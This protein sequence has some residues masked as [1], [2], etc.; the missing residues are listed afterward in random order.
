MW[1]KQ[2]FDFVSSL[3]Q[4]EILNT[5]KMDQAFG[6]KDHTAA[7]SLR[8]GHTLQTLLAPPLSMSSCASGKTLKQEQNTELFIKS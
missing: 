7:S 8:A 1:R 6:E 5:K 2:V 3:C 4:C